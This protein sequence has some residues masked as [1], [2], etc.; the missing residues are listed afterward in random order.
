MIAVVRSELIRIWRPSFRYV[1]IGVMSAFSVMISIFIY[2]SLDS[3][4][5]GGGGGGLPGSGGTSAADLAQPGGMLA[6]LDSVASIAGIVLLALWAI[7]VATDYDTGLIRILV[8]AQPSRTKLLG[9]KIIA[10]TLFTLLATTVT[11]LVTAMAARPLARLY[12]VDTEPWRTDFGLELLTGWFNFT[13][14]ALVWGLIGLTI[15]MLT[16]S[17]GIA[18]AAGIGY[19]LVVEN[20]IAIAAPDITDYLPGG[21]LAALAS[22]GTTDL[23]W[24]AAFGLTT[25][26]GLAAVALATLAF[27]NRDVTS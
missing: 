1:G 22:G 25:A 4:G 17:S 14:P 23:T 24:A 12:D 6:S 27:R 7:A 26:Y 15:A 20:L 10:L 8:Q 2:A 16:R 19:L 5:D 13:V 11:T 21:T 3:G 18:I 9:G